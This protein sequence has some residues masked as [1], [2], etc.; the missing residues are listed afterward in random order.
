MAVKYCHGCGAV[1]VR[2]GN[3]YKCSY[4]PNLLPVDIDDDANAVAVQFAWENLRK[5]YFDKAAE[6]F[7]E[8]LVK[9]KNDYLSHWGLALAKASVVYV[10]DIDN[11][12]KVPT[13]N[14]KRR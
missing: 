5:S 9:D 7:E 13:L 11:D 10:N 1:M 14:N 8:L 4:C 2:E 6:L 3:F 12:K